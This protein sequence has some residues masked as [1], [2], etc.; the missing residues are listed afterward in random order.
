[1]KVGE[2]CKRGVVAIASDADAVE[3]AKLHR[4]DNTMVSAPLANSR[5]IRRNYGRAVAMLYR[6]AVRL[7]SIAQVTRC[8]PGCGELST[9]CLTGPS[10]PCELAPATPTLISQ[11]SIPRYRC[12]RIDQYLRPL[13]ANDHSCCDR[14]RCSAF[15]LFLVCFEGG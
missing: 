6:Y 7:V 9:R 4:S 15:A 14:N 3:A 12:Q 5:Q 1:M 10:R 2:Y 13:S 11:R 8:G